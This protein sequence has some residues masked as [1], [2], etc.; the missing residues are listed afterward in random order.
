[1]KNIISNSI[2]SMLFVVGLTACGGGSGNN[3]SH[4][5]KTEEISKREYVWITYH[6]PKD[7]CTSSIL[8]GELQRIGAKD[9][10]T[11][12]VNGDVTCATYGK[13]NDNDECGTMDTGYYNEPTC[14]VGVNEARSGLYKLKIYDDTQILE[15]IKEIVIEAY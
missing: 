15:N 10:I 6:Y 5:S 14:V 8:R 2:I 12:V 9:I 1:M 4:Q 11:S 7:V 3:S 13:N